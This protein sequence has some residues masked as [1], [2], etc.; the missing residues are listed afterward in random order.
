MPRRRFSWFVKIHTRKTLMEKSFSLLKLPKRGNTARWILYHFCILV[1]ACLVAHKPELR[2]P[3]KGFSE[4]L[5]SPVV[6]QSLPAAYAGFT[7]GGMGRGDDTVA[8]I[9]AANTYGEDAVY[10]WLPEGMQRTRLAVTEARRVED[11]AL[12]WP[13][14]AWSG[15]APKVLFENLGVNLAA[16]VALPFSFPFAEKSFDAIAVSTGGRVMMMDDENGVTHHRRLGDGS[17]PLESRF[18][19]REIHSLFVHW[20]DWAL[21]PGSVVE[22]CAVATNVNGVAVS[23]MA[24]RW[25]NLGHLSAGIT[26]TASFGAV[27]WETGDV[28]LSYGSGAGLF[29]DVATSGAQSGKEGAFWI[30]HDGAELEVV[31]DGMELKFSRLLSPEE[32]AEDVCGDGGNRF[33]KWLYGLDETR[34]S[35]IGDGIDDFYKIT[36]GLDLFTNLAWEV[37]SP[38]GMT[39]RDAYRYQCSPWADFATV[40]RIAQGLDPHSNWAPPNQGAGFESVLLTLRGG[41]DVQGVACFSGLSNDPRVE[42]FVLETNEV[43][44]V[45]VKMWLGCENRVTASNGGSVHVTMPGAH[46]LGFRQGFIP[47]PVAPRS[48]PFM[49]MMFM[50]LAAVLEEQYTCLKM[51][52][53]A[54]PGQPAPAYDVLDLRRCWPHPPGET[55]GFS[56]SAPAFWCLDS[57]PPA[58][59][60]HVDAN[61]THGGAITPEES[62]ACVLCGCPVSINHTYNTQTRTYSFSGSTPCGCV[63]AGGATTLSISQPDVSITGTKNFSPDLYETMSI[64]IE[65]ENYDSEMAN[66]FTYEA[67]V[68]RPLK[69]GGDQQIQTLKFA[70]GQTSHP[71]NGKTISLSWDGMLSERNVSAED[72]PD[73]FT[74][75]GPDGVQSLMNR[76]LP[77]AQ[78]GQTVPLPFFDVVVSIYH[79]CARTNNQ[80]IHYKTIRHRVHVPQ[81]VVIKW[82]PSLDWLYPK[83]LN[84]DIGNPAILGASGPGLKEWASDRIIMYMQNAFPSQMNMRYVNDETTPDAIQGFGGNVK[85]VWIYDLVPSTGNQDDWGYSADG[86]NGNQLR[87]GSADINL[88][89]IRDGLLKEYVRIIRDPNYT[90]DTPSTFSV[91]HVNTLLGF[92][93]V[94]EV[95]H[96]LG[97]VSKAYLGGLDDDT[98]QVGHNCSNSNPNDYAK[99]PY[100]FLNN[101]KY[102]NVNTKLGFCNPPL[103]WK[104][105][106]RDY[107]VFILPKPEGDD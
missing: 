63:S 39:V 46:S 67:K 29:A 42:K 31:G 94:H 69:G 28:T 70:N 89:A 59:L 14:V 91:T 8:R 45:Q 64:A 60:S 33:L 3:S 61:C 32:A 106:N 38:T 102:L 96:T 57:V 74:G 53:R 25:A 77:N 24:I 43:R 86:R 5:K 103:S 22:A 21:G 72:G 10:Y 23:G 73:V 27:L 2:A 71:I 84:D 80:K 11:V 20:S 75:V 105:L 40:T 101:G 35:F 44:M 51:W 104:P 36:Y 52:S 18:V 54:H 97:L 56:I 4:A 83:Q 85:T 7:A 87:W 79:Q 13:D 19:E 1:T 95:G 30:A 76:K 62:K 66:H 16:L 82:M 49:P 50:A 47:A 88:T 81:V 100:Y 26:N 6:F 9:W 34:A 90:P 68:V 78:M 48:A 37:L 93:I 99:T 41:P 12:A 15:A 58:T 55:H 92:T 17:L 65:T 98:S 107:L